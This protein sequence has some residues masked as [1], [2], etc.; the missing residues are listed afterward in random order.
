[1]PEPTDPTR[2]DFLAIAALGVAGCVAMPRSASAPRALRLYVGTYT[3]DRRSRGIHHLEVERDSGQL[4]LGAL[5]AEAVNPSFLAIAPDGRTLLAVSERTEYEG[6]ETGAVLAFARDPATGALTA[7]GAQP[8]GGGAPCYVSLDR[9]GRHALVANYV[10]GSVASLRVAADG[11]LAPATRVVRHAGRGA[12]PTRQSSPHAHAIL[13][14]PANRFA[15]VADLGIDRVL[16]HRFD[17]DGGALV[18]TDG[19]ALVPTDR[20]A[21][22]P[23]GTGPRHLAFAPDGR[24]VY[25]TGELASTLTVLAYDPERGALRER[26]TLSTRPAGASG[27]NF[28]GEV[29]VHPSGRT[30]Y[31]SNRGDD[32][33]AVFDVAADGALALVQTI[34]AGGRWPRHFAL[35]PEG[36]LLLVAHQRSDSVAAFRVDPGTGRLAATG[37]SVA[38]PSP[39]CLLFV[40]R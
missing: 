27:D 15:L 35:D 25:V 26:Q 13:V 38:I 5:A 8:S 33:L 23:P 29:R 11:T 18:P 34:A 16:V 31:A 21:T 6:Q 39:V 37:S 10:G 7:R 9:S 36:R 28:P 19:G 3:N 1:M 12:H 30:V 32:T 14:D 40:D 20:G 2:R 17:A 24:S 4:R 22:L